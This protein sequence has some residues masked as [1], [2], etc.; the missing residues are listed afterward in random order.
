MTDGRAL[1]P[2]ALAGLFWVNSDAIYQLGLDGRFTNGNEALSAITGYE[3]DELRTLDFRDVIHPADRERIEGEF[4][5][6]LAGE[7]RRYQ[8]SIVTK[9]G[10]TTATDV[11]KFPVRDD[12]GNITAILGV[13]RDL[14]PLREV[15]LEADR[16]T[17]LLRIASRLSRLAGWTI[18][19]PDW[20]LSWSPEL[21]ALI[22][23]TP[24]DGAPADIIRQILGPER[25]A[26][27][28]AAMRT[29]AEDGS[30]IEHLVSVHTLDG[31][32]LVIQV[33]GEAM[34]NAAGTVIR[35]HGAFADVSNAIAEQE[36]KL[37]AERRLRTTLDQ[38][39]DG[40]AF[41]GRDWQIS[42]LNRAAAAT[43]GL[44]H[45]EIVGRTVWEL[46]PEIETN[47]VGD[48]YRTVMAGAEQAT[49]RSYTARFEAWFEV[50][51]APTDEGI[52]S[53]IRDVTEDENRRRQLADHTRALESQAALIEATADAMIV[54]AL[55]GRVE[56]W[57]RGAEQMYDWPREDAIGRMILDLIGGDI[58]DELRQQ[59]RDDGRWS[60]ELRTRSRD[61]RDIVVDSRLQLLPDD[62]GAST[63]VLR[64]DVDVSE[65]VADR[66]QARALEVRLQTTLN[67]ISD[68][69][70]FFDRSWRV[71]F[72]NE[73]GEHFMQMP[74]SVSLGGNIWELFPDLADSEF[75]AAY[76]RTM[77]E[78]VVSTARGHYP[79]LGTWFM[80]TSYP[81][82]EGILVYFQDV[83][84]Q[85]TVRQEIEEQNRRLLVQGRLLDEAADAM[86]VRTLDH[87]VTYW[88]RAAT[89]LYGWTL[90][91]VI[92]TSIFDLI[93]VEPNEY[94]VAHQHVLD[95]GS[96]TGELRQY[97]EDGTPL[98]VACRWQLI[99][100]DDGQPIGVFGANSDVTEARREQEQR[101]RAQRME[102]L[103]TLA[104]G[105]AHDL[106]NVLTPILMSVQLLRGGETDPSRLGL[107]DTM[108][109]GVKRG[110]DMIR[111]VLSFARG[112]EGERAVL[113]VEELVA[114][115]ATFCRDTMPKSII[116]EVDVE[117]A[118]WTVVGD[119]TQLIQ[120]LIN[121]AT[122]A[123]DAMPSGGTIS[124]RA[125]N[126]QRTEQH[127]SGTS[128][129]PP[130]R[131]VS[132]D[133]EDD[134]E[135]M[136]AETQSKIFEPFFTTKPQ[137]AGTG[138]GLPTSMAIVRSH[139]G[140]IEVYSEP[141]HGTR[142]Q[143]HIPA[144]DEGD[145]VEHVLEPV[146]EFP[147][148][149]GEYVLVVDDEVA[150]RQIVRQTLDAYGYQTLE[151]GNGRE[152]VDIIE[153]GDV[154]IDLV[155]TDMMM[156]VMDGAATAK[157]LFENRPEIVVVTASGLNAN[158]G[159]ARARDLGVSHFIA[160]PFTTDALLRTLREAL[161]GR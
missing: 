57:N 86:F 82:D 10:R 114:E 79:Q 17:T 84:E 117:D 2:A 23:A 121:F 151:A 55:D 126:I 37:R 158:G 157:Y 15:V 16:M 33:V 20:E 71:T 113:R 64:V 135:G 58:P 53:V 8:T 77:D 149:N 94:L 26:E 92:G 80:V 93:Y 66:E 115:V 21:Y 46:F 35:L 139:G 65:N 101:I 24:D 42:F 1:D 74:R 150:I 87:V 54:T 104:G 25:F 41:I 62:Q 147:R 146:E 5:A 76:R 125:R 19:V 148:G 13:A 153:A 105:I 141:G 29:A 3:I 132:I 18:E 161:D 81:T 137:G 120:V 75:G 160:K 123:R 4:A 122:N 36:Q 6:A 144:A 9:E 96:W 52:A 14:E 131:Y 134:G 60:G 44:S 97:R 145:G 91:D 85:E 112:I 116:V 49:I 129:D 102:S 34:R 28:E 118:L 50:S 100:D 109:A 128:L 140:S 32:D 110:A 59:M 68:G 89:E 43:T 111:Q 40:I 31:R 7:R 39:H 38:L 133:V 30:P 103:G 159:V 47:E 27:L 56:S 78:R 130:G 98:T 106:N 127:H 22:G 142:F 51:A 61:G 143:L 99:R 156:P 90:P 12:D 138:L 119:R 69:V 95:H 11:T 155:L 124:I 72:V 107:L 108:D 73:A 83:S 88:N 136:T 152:A 48:L 67:Q 70:V 154:E 45:D 63:R